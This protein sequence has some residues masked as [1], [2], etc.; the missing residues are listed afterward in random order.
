MKDTDCIDSGRVFSSL[1]VCFILHVRLP[2]TE[3]EDRTLGGRDVPKIDVL[4][5]VLLALD[6]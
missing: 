6:Y 2:E 4:Q 1:L 3:G 5:C